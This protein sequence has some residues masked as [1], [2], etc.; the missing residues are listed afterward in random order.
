[1]AE[2]CRINY[3]TFREW[4]AANYFVISEETWEE[5]LTEDEGISYHVTGSESTSV[6]EGDDITVD[7]YV[8]N[9]LDADGNGEGDSE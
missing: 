2:E 3:G 7:P 8:D 9:I 5:L 4:I 6:A 1:M